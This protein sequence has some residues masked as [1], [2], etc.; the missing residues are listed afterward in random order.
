VALHRWCVKR[1]AEDKPVGNPNF[2]CGLVQVCF[3]K[4]A[5]HWNVETRAIPLD[6]GCYG[7]TPE[8]MLMH[9]DENTIVVVPAFGVTHTGLYAFVEPLAQA[10]DVF[11]GQTG[12]DAD[13]HLDA[14]SGGFLSRP[15]GQIICPHVLFL[16]LGRDGSRQI[17]IACSAIAMLI[18]ER[19][20]STGL[21]DLVGDGDPAAAIPAV[22]WTFQAGM[23]APFTLFDLSDRLCAGGLAAARLLPARPQQHPGRERHLCR[24]KGDEAPRPTRTCR[25]KL[26]KRRRD[27][28]GWPRAPIHA[29]TLHHPPPSRDGIRSRRGARRP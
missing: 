9:V 25:S 28:L 20:A 13:I 5:R 15:A 1:K 10:L 23:D 6:T 4:F 17:Q 19:I 14:A 29:A 8:K 26:E 21:F 11:Q 7:M 3:H 2:V 16:R 12:L 27:P 24:V 18:A 22:T